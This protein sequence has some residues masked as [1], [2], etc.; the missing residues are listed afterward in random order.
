MLSLGR[1][2]ANWEDN[3]EQPHGFWKALISEKTNAGGL[4][5]KN[6]CVSVGDSPFC[7]ST[8]EAKAVVG[9]TSPCGTEDH[10]PCSVDKWFYYEKK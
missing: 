9:R 3:Q 8:D 6:T 4:N 10:I 2:F 7:C 5:C 1:T